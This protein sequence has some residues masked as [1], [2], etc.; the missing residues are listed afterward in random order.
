[1]TIFKVLCVHSSRITSYNVCYTKLL[2]RERAAVADMDQEAV[3]KWEAFFNATPADG[4]LRAKYQMT[5]R[6]LYEHLFLA[7]ISFNPDSRNFYEIVRSTTPPGEDIRIIP[8][9]RPY[10]DPGETPF[11]YL[12]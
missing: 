2:R 6:Y 7:H 11:Y 4:E 3:W 9:I 12:V 8:T 10:D 1:M 5:A